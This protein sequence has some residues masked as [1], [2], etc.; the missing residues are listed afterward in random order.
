MAHRGPPLRYEAVL[1]E[2]TEDKELAKIRN[3][4]SQTRQL[5]QQLWDAARDTETIETLVKPIRQ[6]PP[7]LVREERASLS[8]PA[9]RGRRVDTP[10]GRVASATLHRQDDGLGMQRSHGRQSQGQARHTAA[11]A[12]QRNPPSSVTK[13]PSIQTTNTTQLAPWWARRSPTKRKDAT[14]AGRATPSSLPAHRQTRMAGSRSRS[15]ARS[16]SPNKA[17]RSS[18]PS[19]ERVRVADIPYE[20]RESL[21]RQR[22]EQQVWETLHR[23]D[24]FFEDI[25]EYRQLHPDLFFGDPPPR[26]AR[27]KTSIYRDQPPLQD[28]E[29]EVS[30]PDGYHYAGTFRLNE[31]L[32]PEHLDHPFKTRDDADVFLLDEKSRQLAAE[33]PPVKVTIPAKLIERIPKVYKHHRRSSFDPGD[34]IDIEAHL[35]KG[36]VPY[37]WSGRMLRA[38][39]EH[40]SLK[41]ELQLQQPRK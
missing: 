26:P 31:R 10:D 15:P 22:R 30:P 19:P 23:E 3:L 9:G 35:H 5:V 29:P 36:Y 1:D 11:R 39:S 8:T 33:E 40:L 12:A 25:Q 6:Y 24:A 18:Q 14:Q 38:G 28:V 17:S 37:L 4:R 2:P 21:R 20:H 32:F 13:P 7:D 34:S 16:A 27:M 41:L